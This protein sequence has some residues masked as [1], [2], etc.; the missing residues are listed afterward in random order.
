MLST[1]SYSNWV[2]MSRGEMQAVNTVNMNTQ[3]EYLD[4]GNGNGLLRGEGWS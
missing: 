1:Y 3:S 2:E 4:Q